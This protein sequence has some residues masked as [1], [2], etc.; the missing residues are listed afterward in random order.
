M[1]ARAYESEN[2]RKGRSPVRP[3]VVAFSHPELVGN[4][5]IYH[6]RMELHVG[7]DQKVLVATINVVLHIVE[8]IGIPVGNPE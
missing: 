8:V 6:Q 1:K 2:L 5:L 3:T 4:I 7:L